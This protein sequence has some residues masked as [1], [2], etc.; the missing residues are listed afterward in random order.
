MSLYD[1]CGWTLLR[2]VAI[3]VQALPLCSRLADR[4]AQSRG[5]TRVGLW[6][7]LLVPF[8]TPE[9]LTGYAYSNFSLSLVHHPE[10][11]ELLY[12]LL[13]ALRVVPIGAAAIYFAPP[14]PLSPEALHCRR[15]MSS[16]WL[17]LSLRSLSPRAGDAGVSQSLSH[18][19][20]VVRTMSGRLGNLPPQNG[21]S[22]GRADNDGRRSSDDPN[23]ER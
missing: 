23:P 10:W 18:A 6:T 3:A 1:A 4:L 5:R 13:V 17:G 9:L 14:S 8:L 7:A 22:A 20:Q 12:A 15:L 16:G 19:T 11:N 21:T 2:S